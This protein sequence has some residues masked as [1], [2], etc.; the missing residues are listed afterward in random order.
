MFDAPS[1]GDGEE[2]DVIGVDIYNSLSHHERKWHNNQRNTPF[3][4][5]DGGE[6][7]EIEIQDWWK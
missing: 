5:G 1:S 2:G 4:V 7:Y 3:V 6:L